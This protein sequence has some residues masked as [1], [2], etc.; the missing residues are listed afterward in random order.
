M[1]GNIDNM[2]AGAELDALIAEKVMGWDHV[3]K[4]EPR[5]SIYGPCSPYY[6]G[7]E[8]ITDG[9]FDEPVPHYST[10]IGTAWQ[11]VEKMQANKWWFDAD[12]ELGELPWAAFFVDRDSFGYIGVYGSNAESMPLAVCRAALKV[13]LGLR[14]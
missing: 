3:R 6:I 12:W 2:L 11:V 13:V 8:N 9:D 7:R 4:I 14:E 5:S 10:Y 1:D